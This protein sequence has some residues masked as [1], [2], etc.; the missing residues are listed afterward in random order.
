M[1]TWADLDLDSTDERLPDLTPVL[2]TD[3][4][5]EAVEEALDERRRSE[6]TVALGALSDEELFACLASVAHVQPQGQWFS[7][8]TERER[9]TARI[10]ALRSLTTRE[11]VFVAGGA[12]GLEASMSRR[13]MALLRLRREPV[14]LSA[15]GMTRQGP[16]WYLLRR[17]DDLW[18]REVVSE[19]GFHS[20][21]LVLLDDH[22]ER[23]F[24]AFS[25]LSDEHHASSVALR[26][27]GDA[28]PSAQLRR[29]L[30]EQ[31]HITQLAMVHPGEDVP[32]THVVCVD[33][34]GAMT[35]AVPEGDDLV[36]SGGSP[37][38]IVDRWHAWRDLW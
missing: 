17:V 11:E 25:A 13:L 6:G 19:H 23:F 29:F 31:R 21:D 33:Q 9:R 20:H 15:Q 12:D 3:D 10:A 16:S 28:P 34:S 26:Q 18:M 7:T 1:T 27:R 35:L 37:A 30:G 32:E 2:D 4:A 8:L 24:R 22:E 36:Y 5:R 38:T 14:L